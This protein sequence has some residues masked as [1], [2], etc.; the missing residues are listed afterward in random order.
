MKELQSHRTESL[1]YLSSG[2]G[3]TATFLSIL[4]LKIS[5]ITCLLFELVVLNGEI[6]CRG[7]HSRFAVESAVDLATNAWS[8]LLL[9]YFSRSV[10]VA[11]AD[12]KIVSR[13][14]CILKLME[15][16]L[17]REHNTYLFVFVSPA[18]VAH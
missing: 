7:E 4:I 14:S 2:V 13:T 1:S 15:F 9:D 5:K 8:S 10:D 12:V 3:I 6:F 17:V 11:N 16:I 18:A